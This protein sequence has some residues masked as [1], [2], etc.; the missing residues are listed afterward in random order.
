MKINMIEQT[1]REYMVNRE[2]DATNATNATNGSDNNSIDMES[3]GNFVLNKVESQ[4][5]LKV[6][7][8]ND[9]KL[10]EEISSFLLAL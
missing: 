4:L 9:N 6:F 10:M 1:V 2:T 8:D 3:I 7:Y 5:D